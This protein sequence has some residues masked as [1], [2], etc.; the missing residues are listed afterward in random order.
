MTATTHA[1]RCQ[2]LPAPT[3]FE[4]AGLY[5]PDAPDA[6]TRLNLLRIVAARGG[7]LADMTAATD[8]ELARL[9]AE[10][11]FRPA[12]DRRTLAQVAETVGIG[13]DALRQLFHVCGL[14]MSNDAEPSMTEADADLAR[15]FLDAT[16]LLGTEAATQLTRVVAASVERIADAAVSAFVTTAGPTSLA[17]DTA[18]VDA[19]SRATSLQDRLP[20]AM[21][22]LLRHHLV[23]LARPNLTGTSAPFEVASAAVGFV[24]LVGFTS[25]A[26]QV[27]LDELGRLLAAFESAATESVA[28]HQGRVVK[29]VGD[30]VMF[31]TT[32]LAH[33]SLVAV[34]VVDRLADTSGQTARGGIAAGRV[35]VRAGD[36]FG[37][38]V[39]LAARAA[40]AAPPAAVV[41]A[42]L[43]HFDDLPAELT[44]TP[45]P[46][47]HLA[48]IDRPVRLRLLGRRVAT[49]A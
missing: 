14:D 8:D 10:R 30:A 41:A 25:L 43:D 33:A 49:A 40:A 12:T 46:R 32:T 29:F 6:T 9:A 19:T 15:I 4:R 16:G 39:N 31:R 44:A 47:A 3:A 20:A 42:T 13:V 5:R 35:L 1:E 26:Q 2:R 45:L 36:C 18:L 11:F 17:D 21:D 24:D 48:G 7:S 38:V 23:R 22:T 28:A 37:P 34:D 27:S